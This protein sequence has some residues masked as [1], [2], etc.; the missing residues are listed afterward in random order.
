M[1]RKVTCEHRERTPEGVEMTLEDSLD[2]FLQCLTRG[3]QLNYWAHMREDGSIARRCYM[4]DHENEIA[5][6]NHWN[7]KLREQLDNR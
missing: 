2:H 1:E 4:A 6:L 7:M 3:Q 5:A